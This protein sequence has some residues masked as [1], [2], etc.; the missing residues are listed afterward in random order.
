MW[1]PAVTAVRSRGID[2]YFAPLKEGYRGWSNGIAPMAH[3]SGLKA[4]LRDGISELVPIPAGR[5]L[6]CQAGL[7]HPS[8]RDRSKIHDGR[9]MDYW[10]RG[11]AAAVD[12]K[13]PYG[14]LM[15]KKGA[16]RDGG[17]LWEREGRVTV[18]NTVMDEDT[19][20]DTA[21]ERF[22]PL[23]ER[24]CCSRPCRRDDRHCRLLLPGIVHLA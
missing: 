21:V 18:W 15:E 5:A 2:C 24:G 12:I 17:S 3:L 22:Y 14:N 19:L 13:D 7:L 9:G 11:Q 23:P 4:G 20:S 8:A 10:Y 16:V 1:S 6:H